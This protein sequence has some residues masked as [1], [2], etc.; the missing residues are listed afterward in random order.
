[1]LTY[2]EVIKNR[3]VDEY[4]N[5]W[6]IDKVDNKIQLVFYFVKDEDYLVV[7]SSDRLVEYLN[8]FPDIRDFQLQ[9]IQLI[10]PLLN[11]VIMDTTLNGDDMLILLPE[12]INGMNKTAERVNK[13]YLQ[14]ILGK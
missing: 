10:R 2:R 8:E 3:L 11:G 5:K 6:N 4:I 7:S 9:S 1:M 14:E 12:E 13:E